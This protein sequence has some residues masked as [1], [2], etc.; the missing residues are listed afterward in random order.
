MPA[1]DFSKRP[2]AWPGE[3]FATCSE[4]LSGSRKQEDRN[5]MVSIQDIGSMFREAGSDWVEDK[6][7]QQGAALAFYSILSLAPL[8]VISLSIAAMVFDEASAREQM[9]GQVEQ[10]VGS[11]GAEAAKSML[12]NAQQPQQG[13]VAAVL[14]IATLLFGA[15]GVFGQLQEA[16]NTVWEVQPKPGGGIWQLIRARFLSLAMVFG[17][18]F[19]LLVSLVLSAAIAGFGSFVQS[20]YP[21]LEPLSHLLNFAITFVVVTL[22][23]ALLFRYLPD[24]E[25]SWGDV[26]VGAMLTALLFT[27]GK[28][29]IG[30][31]LGKSGLGSAYGAAGSLVVLV[32]WIYYSAQIM[33]FGAELTQVYAK[34]FGSRIVPKPGAQAVTN[35]ARAQQ[36]LGP[37]K[38]Q[39][40]TA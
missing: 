10:L 19:L 35:E 27:I 12:E 34:R 29:L 16:L 4:W 3:L 6:A 1:L 7:S 36:G 24:A 8:L 13:T 23:F 5:T 37:K 17:T 38:Q 22:L 28:L 33:L 26:W 31:Y 14:G 2:P 39:Y 11:D 9:I 32:V 15:S 25:V 21:G 40:G 18:G 30:L 20:C